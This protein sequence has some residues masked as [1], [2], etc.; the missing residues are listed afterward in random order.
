MRRRRFVDGQQ[1][2]AESLSSAE[3]ESSRAS[4]QLVL[5]SC[6]AF[7]IVNA[8]VVC[9]YFNADEYWQSLEVAHYLVFGYGH[10]TW[11]WKEAIRSYIHPLLFATVYKVLAVT[12][13]DSPFTLSMAPRLLQGA[14]AA[15]GDL[16]LYR[17]AL[18]LFSPAVANLAL[19]CQ[20]CSWFTFFCAVRTFS[21]SLEAVLT[22]A[23][24]SYWPLPVSWPRGNPEVA[25]SCSSRGAALLL[26]AA[27]VVIR[28]TS[29]A[30]WLP[31]GLAE[32]IAGHNRLVFLFLEVLPIG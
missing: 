21:S 31:I 17:L 13:L 26:A 28:P 18:R 19:F 16:C 12:G 15:Y 22:T 14:F 10:L 2:A 23:A 9:T 1:T 24:L 30:L 27:A 32:L 3:L 6:L 29:L 20:M 7:R 11:E 4:W 25:G 5:T 8:L